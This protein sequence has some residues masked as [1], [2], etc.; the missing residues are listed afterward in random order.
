MTTTRQGRA[1]QASAPAV[2]AW[3]A[4][5]RPP[6]GWSRDRQSGG[7][8]HDQRRS[9]APGP[10]QPLLAAERG[11]G[12]AADGG[13]GD[14]GPRDGSG[15]GTGD[16]ALG[17]AASGPGDDVGRDPRRGEPPSSAPDVE[18]AAA[19]DRLLAVAVDELDEAAIGAQLEVIER[20]SR[21][22]EA[23]RCRLAAALAARRADQ[24]QRDADAQGQDRFRA[25][26]RARRQAED[27]LAGRYRWSKSDAKRATHVGDLLGDDDVTQAA[28]DQGALPPR[29]AQLLADTLRHLD[30]D[31]RAQAKPTLL[32]AAAEQ[33]A[34]TFG[35]SCRRLLATLDADAAMR[36]EQRRHQRRRAAVAPTDDGMLAVTGQWA[37]VDAETV[38]TAIDAYRRPDPPGVRR[39]AEQRTADAIVELAAAALRAGDAPTVHGVRPHVSVL[40]DHQTILAD[41]DAIDAGQAGAPKVVEAPWT[42]PLPFAE[43]RRL[44]ADA[45]VARLLVDPAGIPLEA[46]EEVRTVPAGLWRSLVARDGG[47]I[48]DGC[49]TPAGWCDVMHLDQPFR[50]DGQLSLDNAALGCRH[51]HRCFDHHGWRITWDDRRPRLHPPPT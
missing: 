6:G 33:D 11:G 16:G 7:L 32:A 51:H 12:Y 3:R 23:R 19:I 43:I 20:A 30:A 50:L 18:L 35:R 22:L 38:A 40:I 26:Q 29:H 5:S 41:A 27:E 9:T 10:G 49:D 48:V 13:S 36:G 37:G 46:G 31:Q 47:C 15:G 25:G 4:R 24:A 8:H 1:R 28:F 14:D 17:G 42:G 44:L 34:T 45:G 2:R 39:T 21:R